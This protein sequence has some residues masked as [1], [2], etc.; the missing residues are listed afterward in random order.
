MSSLCKCNDI[1]HGRS[2]GNRQVQIEVASTAPSTGL[3]YYC[4]IHGNGMGNTITVKD[5]N[6]SLVAGS[7]ANVNLDWCRIDKY[8]H[9]SGFYCK[10]KY[11]VAMNIDNVT[12]FR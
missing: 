7:I 9:N 3:R 8:K 11:N 6:V 4:Y 2:S 5:S 10:C 12:V 1:Q